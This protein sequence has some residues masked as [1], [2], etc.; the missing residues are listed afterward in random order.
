MHY[1]DRVVI[2][3]VSVRPQR[4]NEFL[5]A[6]KATLVGVGR[7][8]KLV[9][10]VAHL[11]LCQLFQ[12]IYDITQSINNWWGW[13]YRAYTYIHIFVSLAEFLCRPI[14]PD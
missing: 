12:S 7:I 2:S 13:A 14:V 4:A 1:L 8:E 11:R 10:V 5:L 6:E 9:I 3:F